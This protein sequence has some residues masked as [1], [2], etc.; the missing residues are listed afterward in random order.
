[1]C[2]LQL[3]QCALEYA[4]RLKPVEEKALAMLTRE[5]Q[6]L[7]LHGLTASQAADRLREEGY[8]DLPS[9]RQRGLLGAILLTLA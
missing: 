6:S 7:S 9:Q 4:A 8:N 2:W 1:M 3:R 5:A